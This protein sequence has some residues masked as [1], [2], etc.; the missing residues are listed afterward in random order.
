LRFSGTFLRDLLRGLEADF[1][2]VGTPEALRPFLTSNQGRR[3]FMVVEENYGLQ[4][5][6]FVYEDQATIEQVREQESR[7]L[8]FLRRKFLEDLQEGEKIFV[9][10]RSNPPLSES[11]MLPL[12]FALRR[13]G[14]GTLL[15]VEPADEEN[16]PGSVASVGPGLLRGFIDRFAPGENAHDLSLRVWLSVCA[17]AYVLAQRSRS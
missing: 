11:E 9:C 6:T 15:W 5:H 2:G 12:L 10:S 16:P 4:Y 8:K 17:N 13:H 7:K 3:E 14:P 1:A